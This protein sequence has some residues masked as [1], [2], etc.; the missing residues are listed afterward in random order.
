MGGSIDSS[1]IMLLL[2]FA[3]VFLVAAGLVAVSSRW[4]R[5][6]ASAVRYVQNLLSARNPLLIKTSISV[7]AAERRLREHI[8]RVGIPI[9]MSERLVGRFT[10]GEIKVQ[11]HRPFVNTSRSLVF[12]GRIRRQNGATEIIGHTRLH[13]YLQWF[14]KVFFGFLLVWSALGIPAGILSVLAGQIEGLIFIAAP[15]LMIAGG[16]LIVRISTGFGEDGHNR[17]AMLLADAVGGVVV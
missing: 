6:P 3:I 13:L 15:F 1:F 12:V 2:V 4:F 9:L 7:G 8:S 10:N 5:S 14:M 16:I 17:I 11:A